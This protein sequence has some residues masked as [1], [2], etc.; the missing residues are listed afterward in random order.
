MSKAMSKA[1]SKEQFHDPIPMSR[2][3]ECQAPE[4]KKSKK[5]LAKATG[6]GV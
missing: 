2:S 6:R 4:L 3:K 5:P 1:M